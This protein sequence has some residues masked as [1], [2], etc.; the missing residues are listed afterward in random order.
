MQKVLKVR[1]DARDLQQICTPASDHDP[2]RGSETD[3]EKLPPAFL[4]AV[5]GKYVAVSRELQRSLKGNPMESQVGHNA[6]SKEMQCSLK[7]NAMQS[8]GKA[9]SAIMIQIEGLRP[10]WKSCRQ[11]F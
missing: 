8:Q 2:D 1:A 6:A 5:Q 3:L 7:G 9:R 4:K 10:S 11:P